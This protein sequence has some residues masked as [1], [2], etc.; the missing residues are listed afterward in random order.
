MAI[1][2]IDLGLKRIGLAYSP[3]GKI[4]VALNP[5][6]RKNRNQAANEIRQIINEKKIDH[7]VIGVAVGGA[8][9]DEMRRR[10]V[11]FINLLEC[12]CAVS[13]QDESFSSKEAAVFAGTKK[14][15]RIDSISAL[16][17]LERFLASEKFS[18]A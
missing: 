17:I 12:S 5:I 11:H 16:I 2:A 14:D 1:L 15:G 13:F 4:A 18:I 9:E 6:M 8:S 3:A 7:I 10:A